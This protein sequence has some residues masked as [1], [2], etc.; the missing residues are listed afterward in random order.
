MTQSGIVSSEENDM[1]WEI[2]ARERVEYLLKTATWDNGGGCVWM[3]AETEH[4]HTPCCYS[5]DE[6]RQHLVDAYN[7][8][9][10]AYVPFEGGEAVYE[11]EGT[12]D[13]VVADELSAYEQQIQALGWE[14]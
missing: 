9:W 12:D 11:P 6:L 4:S 10:C 3:E 5:M 14:L 13:D 8:M 7:E 1:D 2:Q